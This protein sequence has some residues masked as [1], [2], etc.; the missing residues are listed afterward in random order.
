VNLP[1]VGLM[2]LVL[3]VVRQDVNLVA[4]A[5]RD[6]NGSRY[7]VWDAFSTRSWTM[8]MQTAILLMGR[9]GQLAEPWR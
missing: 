2:W 8:S 7:L 1:L 3:D 9:Q 4:S 6:E 5:G